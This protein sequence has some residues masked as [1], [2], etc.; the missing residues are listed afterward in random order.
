MPAIAAAKPKPAQQKQDLE[1]VLRSPNDIN[2]RT[3]GNGPGGSDCEHMSPP[4][5]EV[6]HWL[7]QVSSIYSDWSGSVTITQSKVSVTTMATSLEEA[8]N[9]DMMM[10]TTLFSYSGIF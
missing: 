6:N 2:I 3:R 7:T 1:K 4:Y 8:D 9:Q 10:I 5:T